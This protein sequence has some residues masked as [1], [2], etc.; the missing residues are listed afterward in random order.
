MR[1][2]QRRRGLLVGADEDLRL[3]L[4]DGPARGRKLPLRRPRLSGAAVAP[5][6]RP[7]RAP[8]VQPAI[9]MTVRKD[10]SKVIVEPRLWPAELMPA[11]DGA[12]LPLRQ[13]PPAPP[14]PP[15]LPSTP[16]AAAASS[17]PGG[18][19]LTRARMKKSRTG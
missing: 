1:R 13:R 2:T 16:A 7:I 14:S 3:V 17:M 9:A 12:H 18:G 4:H 19:S 15:A 11:A 8:A 6:G 10:C 5:Q